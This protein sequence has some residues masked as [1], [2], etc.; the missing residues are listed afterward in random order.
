MESFSTPQRFIAA[1]SD[2]GLRIDVFCARRR[3]LASRSKVQKAIAQGCVSLNGRPAKK[4]EHVKKGDVVEVRADGSA[5]GPDGGPRAQNIAI[6][7]LYEDE[8]VLAIDKPAG[9]VVHPGSGVRDNTLV[10]ALLYHV[11]RLSAA[12]PPDRPG[13]IHRLDKDTSGV[14]LVA[15]TEVAHHAFARLFALRQIRKTYAAV[16]IG[17]RPAGHGVVEAALGRSRRDRT[18]QSVRG[19]GK[20]ARTEYRLIAHQ[21]GLSLLLLFPHTGRTHQIRLHCRHAGFPVV[22]DK[23]YG[24]GSGG[25]L[26]LEPLHRPFAHRVLKCFN[27]QALHA[28]SISFVHPMSGKETRIEAPLPEDFTRVLPLFG[29]TALNC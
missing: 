10:N 17:A 18:K 7:V 29:V 19:D 3:P 5:E 22:G 14:L 21:S 13:I 20:A 9:M 1:E 2:G 28:C 16:C 25:V 6:S 11:P 12:A 24:A 23:A 26:A 4:N 8:H 27:R 15:K